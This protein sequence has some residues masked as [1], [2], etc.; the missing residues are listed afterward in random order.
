MSGPRGNCPGCGAPVSFLWSS[1]VQTACQ[2]C[3]SILVRRD[4]DLERVGVV[5]DLPEDASPIQ[6]GTEGLIDGKPF[7]VAGRIVY[8][9]EQGR[10]NEWHLI[11]NDGSSAWLSDAQLEYAVSFLVPLPEPQPGPADQLKRG[12]VFQW[13]GIPYN[14]TV[15]TKATYEGFQGELPFT[16]HDRRESTFADFRTEDGRFATLDYSEAPPLLF[17]GRSV[18]FDDLKLR[19]LRE[20]EGW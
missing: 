7:T 11:L 10:W 13:S 8:G 2:F 18:G 3:N 19:G 14:L 17:L 15:I 9:W 20:F 5:A 6:I 4:V 12:Q 1:A 16:T